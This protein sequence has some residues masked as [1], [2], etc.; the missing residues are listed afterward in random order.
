MKNSITDMIKDCK[1]FPLKS[2]KKEK[3]RGGIGVL[4]QWATGRDL[5]SKSSPLVSNVA[6]ETQDKREKQMGRLWTDRFRKITFEKGQST[7]IVSELGRKNH[8]SEGRPQREAKGWENAL[9]YVGRVIPKE[10]VHQV[11]HACRGE[12]L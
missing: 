1:G 5:I 8:I 11:V 6:N 10:K 12:D 7:N 2:S 4:H 3:D 9:G